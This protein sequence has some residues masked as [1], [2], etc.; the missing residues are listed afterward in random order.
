MDI[1]LNVRQQCALAA[2]KMD[3]FW[4]GLR[5]VLTARCE[6]SVVLSSGEATGGVLDAVLGSPA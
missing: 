4:A 3:G 5:K 2:K 1:K 6:T